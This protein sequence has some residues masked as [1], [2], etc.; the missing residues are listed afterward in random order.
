MKKQTKLVAVLSTAALLAVGASMS[1][2]AAQGWQEENGTWVYY[3]KSGDHVTE[4]WAKSGDNWFYLNED[5]EMTTDAIVEDEDNYYYVNESGAMV[6]NKWVSVENEE[7]DGGSD[8]DEPLNHWYYFGANGKAYKSSSSNTTASFKTINGKK[9]IFDD[10][11]KMLFGWIGKDGERKTGDDAWQKDNGEYYCGDENDGAQASG[12][13]QIEIEDDGYNS[14]STG[15]SSKN[16]YDD[17]NQTRWFYFKSNGKKMAGEKG[18]TI[19]GK[20]YGFDE[21]GRMNA[22]WVIYDADPT[23]DTTDVKRATLADA[24]V[25]GI[26]T[27]SQGDAE[28]SHNWRYYG[29]PED[30]ARVTKGWFKVVPDENLQLKKYNDDEDFWYYSDKDG[31]LV[32]SELKTINGKKYAFD[33][34]GRMKSGLKFIRFE[35]SESGRVSSTKISAILDDDSIDDTKFD[36]EENFLNSAND[37]NEA[38]YYAYYFGDGNDGSM[39]TNKQNVSI[40][41]ESFRFMFNK[42][43]SFKGSGKTGESDDKYYLSGML[44]KADKDDKYS[45]IKI[46]KKD[47]DA[48]TYELLDTDE[49]IDDITKNE[50]LGDADTIDKKKSDWSEAWKIDNDKVKAGKIEYKLVNTSGTVQKKKTKAKDGNDR[51][52][53]QSGSNIDYIYVED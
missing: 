15:H 30:G 45:V 51:C 31:K 24:S 33:E 37:L 48:V 43:G 7:Y 12:W 23:T 34:Y 52:Y 27:A 25:L 21:H 3:D 44:L 17:E 35:V 5:G 42:S 38:G 8:D 1:S 36:T 6:T 29:S 14:D 16:V 50:F 20:K 2:F 49:F 10:E 11:G 46:N 53:V 9:Y 41:G 28:Y 47:A 26:S 39:K 40:D 19:N 13:V 4:K 32:A 22:E 18:K